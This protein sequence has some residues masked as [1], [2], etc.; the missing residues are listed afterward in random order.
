MAKNTTTPM[1]TDTFTE[2]CPNCGKENEFKYIGRAAIYFCQ[3]CRET[4]IPC[5][6]CD[7][8]IVNCDECKANRKQARFINHLEELDINQE[9]LIIKVDY[10]NE[11]NP[12][13]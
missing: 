8:D 9:E 6:L 12:C 10:S 3:H 7:M 11:K 1:R 5:S 2:L 4:L 13:L